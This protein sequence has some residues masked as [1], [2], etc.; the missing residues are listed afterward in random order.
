MPRSISQFWFDLC[1][2]SFLWANPGAWMW[3]LYAQLAV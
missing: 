3:R 2:R 1:T